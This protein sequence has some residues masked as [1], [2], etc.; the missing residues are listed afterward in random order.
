MADD[1]AQLA[2]EWSERLNYEEHSSLSEYETKLLAF[3]N[4]LSATDTK[5]FV[6]MELQEATD[7]FTFVRS[8]LGLPPGDEEE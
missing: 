7:Y 5:R 8:R 4:L 2:G 1:F 6:T 3:G